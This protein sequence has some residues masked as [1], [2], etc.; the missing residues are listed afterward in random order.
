VDVKKVLLSKVDKNLSDALTENISTLC[1]QY[2]HMLT[3]RFNKELPL[4]LHTVEITLEPSVRLSMTAKPKGFS[5]AWDLDVG[6][7]N[8]G[9]SA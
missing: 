6:T 3:D 8:L 4:G 2:E 5:K 9:G 7:V 1:K